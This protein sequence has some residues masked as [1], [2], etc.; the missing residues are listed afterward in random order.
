MCIRDSIVHALVETNAKGQ[1]LQAAGQSHIIYA[2]VEM[3]TK[4]Q[5][6]QAAGQSYFVHALLDL[7]RI[8]V[9]LS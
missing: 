8:S 1:A 4:G 3:I 2:L 5:A 6:L 9:H 7:T